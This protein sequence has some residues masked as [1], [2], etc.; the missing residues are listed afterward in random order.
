MLYFFL[1]HISDLH[2]FLL[3]IQRFFIQ[4]TQDSR[5][6]QLNLN[7][8]SSPII[9]RNQIQLLPKFIFP[10]L[11]PN[12]FLNLQKQILLILR[13]KT[14][15]LS[16]KSISS[17]STHTMYI[18]RYFSWHMIIYYEINIWYIKASRC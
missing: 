6:Q 14:N 2:F 10:N 18:I 5:T 1:F 4:L 9:L 7:L 12:L 16:L 11:N 8:P 17:S 13:N 3:F 15:R